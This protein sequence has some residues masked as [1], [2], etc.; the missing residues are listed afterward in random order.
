MEIKNIIDKLIV[1]DKS[2]DYK[3]FVFYITNNEITNTIRIVAIPITAV[4]PV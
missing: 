2:L 3:I 4:T 1:Y